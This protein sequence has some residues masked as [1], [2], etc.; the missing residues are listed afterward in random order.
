LKAEYKIGFGNAMKKKI[1]SLKDGKIFRTKEV[2][3][4]EDKKKLLLV[5]DGQGEALSK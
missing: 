2:Y 1:V 3:E 4:D 5:K